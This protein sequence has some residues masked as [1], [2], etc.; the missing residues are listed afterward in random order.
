MNLG[1]AL[2]LLRV[3]EIRLNKRGVNNA[4]WE[5]GCVVKKKIIRIH[6]KLSLPV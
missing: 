5:R 4:L 2:A 6:M 1:I 3:I